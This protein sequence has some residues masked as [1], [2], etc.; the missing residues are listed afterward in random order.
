[1]LNAYG[2]IIGLFIIGGLI[3]ALWGGVL[4]ARARR[5]RHWP[6]VEGVIEASEVS[7]HTDDLLPHIEYSYTVDG[8]TYRR[9]VDFP[10]GTTPTQ[11]LSASY[12]QK[13]PQGST[14]RVHYD[15]ADPETATLAPGAEG[16]DWLVLAFGLGAVLLGILMLFL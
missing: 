14:V 16:G 11:E 8:N 13:Y 10:A 3:A 6:S 5:T 9:V 2:L 4:I 1:M 12:L 15:P 7:S